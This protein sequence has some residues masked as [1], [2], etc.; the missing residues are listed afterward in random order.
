MTDPTD[1]T[2]SPASPST[3]AGSHRGVRDRPGGRLRC[4][5][6]PRRP[7]HP[8]PSPYMRQA[9]ARTAIWFAPSIRPRPGAPAMIA[10]SFAITCRALEKVEE[11]LREEI[12]D[13]RRREA[14]GWD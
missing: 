8:P 14:L 11:K 12:E 9:L 4:R 10:G 13:A 7:R 5:L 2:A 1:A 6:R 3:P